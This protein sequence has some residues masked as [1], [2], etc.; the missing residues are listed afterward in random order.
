MIALHNGIEALDRRQGTAPVV[1]PVADNDNR[2]Q[3][4]ELRR[5][6]PKHARKLSK[7]IGQVLWILLDAG[8]VASACMLALGGFTWSGSLIMVSTA[9]LFVAA[10]AL[11]YGYGR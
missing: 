2:I 10:K 7:E 8:V 4:G 11:S 1:V 5:R 3:P 6:R 9:A